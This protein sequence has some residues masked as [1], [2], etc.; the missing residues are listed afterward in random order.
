MRQSSQFILAGYL[1][2]LLTSGHLLAQ[3]VMPRLIRQIGETPGISLKTNEIEEDKQGRLWMATHN[4]LVQFD[5]KQFRVFHD[6]ALKQGDYYYHCVF[7]PDGRIWLKQD[8]GYALPYFDPQRQQIRRVADTTRLIR[9]YLAKYGCHYLFADTQANL[10]IGLR[11]QGMIRFNPRTGVVD[12]VFNQ[13]ANV[14][15]ITQDKQGRIWFTS[16]QGLYVYHP[17]TASLTAYRP[18][19]QHPTTSLGSLLTYGLCVRSDGTILVGLDNEVDLLNPATGQI[20][21]FR[22]IPSTRFPRQAV[23]D[24]VD[25]PEG[26]T[27]FL[28]PTALYRYTKRDVIERI[29]LQHPMQLPS[30]CLPNAANRLWVTA[31]RVLYEYDL[32][33]MRPL[34]PLNLL[35]VVVNG[36]RLETNSDKRRLE[37]DSLGPSSPE[38]IT[39][40]IQ[41]NDLLSIRFS[42]YASWHSSTFRFRLEG[43][44]QQWNVDEGLDVTANYQLPAGNYT[45]VVNRALKAGQWETRQQTFRLVVQPPFWKTGWFLLLMGIVLTSG[46]LFLYRSII[47]RYRLRQQ[48]VQRQM[49][50]DNLRQLDE[51]KSRFFTNITHEFRTPL[52]LILGPIEQLLHEG[53]SPAIQG[54]LSGIETH[55]RQLLGLINQLMDL[56]K[57]EAGMMPVHTS[58]GNLTEFIRTVISGF[59][60]QAESQTITLAVTGHLEGDY[61]FDA[62]KLKQILVN[63]LSNALKFTPKG[64]RI[65]VSIQDASPLTLTVTDT[66]IGI[67]AEQLPLIFNRFYQVGDTATRPRS[68]DDSATGTTPQEGTGIGLALV[69]ELTERQ[70]GQIKAE[71]TVG[72]GTSFTLYLPCRP[73][74]TAES[75]LAPLPSADELEEISKEIDDDH[76]YRPIVLI[77][78]DNRELAEFITQSLPR[79]YQIHWARN[80]AEGL[81]RAMQLMPDLV[82]SDVLMPVEVVSIQS[83]SIQAEPELDGFMLCNRLKNDSR[84]SHIPVLLLTAKASVESRLEGLAQGADDYLTK[85]FQVTELQLRVR[86]QLASRQRL[87]DWVRSTLDSLDPA[88]LASQAPDPFLAQL[89]QLM[90]THLP[91]ADFNVET[92]MNQLSLSRSNLFRKVKTLTGLSANDLLR[93]YRL[94]QSTY[95]LR[96]GLTVSETAYR[97]GFENPAYFTKCFRKSYGLTPREFANQS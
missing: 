12:H 4:G 46:L 96:E 71:S 29:E 82:I 57:L 68:A 48:L 50:A 5:G 15:W 65:T 67:A 69:K 10:W 94:K 36:T 58:H 88:P 18:D 84:T 28:T 47:N 6:P 24:I 86:N 91:D 64:G 66:G 97:V 17:I 90:D 80:G 45:F 95:Y 63:L 72:Q 49:E 8:E 26:N 81:E 27:Y 51:M 54:R 79:D 33:Q 74:V 53:Q 38:Q 43:F 77:V 13:K 92:M 32:K 78:E 83:G 19:P 30:D 35:D 93:Q 59:Q 41:E 22:L 89:Y 52:T 87:R 60:A 23:F 2:A 85:P 21:R 40:T 70:G 31:G 55:A 42:P 7:S 3:Q 34:P 14:R 9:D 76:A 1:L 75:A 73:V 16:D 39:L 56:A 25:D 44:D 11:G 37:R 62:D 20:R 61:W